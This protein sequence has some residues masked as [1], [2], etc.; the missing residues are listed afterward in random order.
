MPT[1]R[2]DFYSVSVSLDIRLA[3]KLYQAELPPDRLLQR[4]NTIYAFRYV[5]MCKCYSK[6]KYLNCE[7]Y[8]IIRCPQMLCKHVER[9]VYQKVFER[10]VGEQK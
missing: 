3:R 2:V 4:E 6:V 9:R 5:P 1:I 7:G 8:S 10:C